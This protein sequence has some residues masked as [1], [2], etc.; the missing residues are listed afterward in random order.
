MGGRAARRGGRP[1]L[2]RS[3][4][5]RLVPP[6]PLAL[7]GKGQHHQADAVRYRVRDAKPRQNRRRGEAHARL[8]VIGVVMALLLV[9]PT[10]ASGHLGSSSRAELT[11]Y[12][13]TRSAWNAQHIADPNPRL[14]RGCCFLP[15][16]RDGQ[17]RY[18][19][20]QY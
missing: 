17:D 14:A 20:V 4:D 5:E 19:A 15:K 1:A 6:K 3:T 12:G 11:A 7:D 13:A 2:A 10:P 8:I 18:F 9:L 16:Q